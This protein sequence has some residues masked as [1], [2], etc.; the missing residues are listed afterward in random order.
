M[1]YRNNKV[2]IAV[3][4][5]DQAFQAVRYVSLV[6]QPDKT[7][8][9]LFHVKTEI[10]FQEIENNPLYRSRM[11]PIRG[12]IS[13]QTNLISNFMKKSNKLLTDAGF[14]KDSIKIKIQSKMVGITRDIIKE[15]THGDDKE[16]THDYSAVI[17]GRVGTHKL[18]SS[19]IGSAAVKLV[20]KIKNIPLIVVGGVPTSKK[21]LVAFDATEA[22]IQ[23][24]AHLGELVGTSGCKV[25]L[26]HIYRPSSMFRIGSDR[27]LL[28]DENLEEG[29][30]NCAVEPA[31]ERARTSLINAGVLRKNISCNLLRTS[32][33]LASSLVEKA[34]ASKSG[35]IVMG[36]QG[37]ST[38]VEEFFL[39]RISKKVLKMT[40]ESVV[41]IVS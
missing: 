40:E 30:M 1:S 5:S 34:K 19:I 16:T 22:S 33:N 28:Q 8:V 20:G 4:G 37:L 25:V 41:W 39:G 21:I 17:V 18:K 36:K 26:C 13:D 35:S 31:F 32:M 11:T 7:D 2:L 23:S 10:P 38:F 24:A 15:T 29:V 27:I 6:M 12:W 3:D 9:V 14:P